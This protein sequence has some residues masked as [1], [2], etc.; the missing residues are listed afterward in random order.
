LE[1]GE[2]SISEIV[3]DSLCLDP[4]VSVAHFIF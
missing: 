3:L 1:F 4:A 2:Q